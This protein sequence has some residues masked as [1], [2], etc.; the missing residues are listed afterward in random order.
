MS[1]LESRQQRAF[2]VHSQERI[3]GLLG[4]MIPPENQASVSDNV[5]CTFKSVDFFKLLFTIAM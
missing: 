4:A 3:M 1:D 2:A 5:S